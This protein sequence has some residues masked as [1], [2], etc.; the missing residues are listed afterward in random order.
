MSANLNYVGQRLSLRKPQAESLEILSKFIKSVSL[1]KNT[2]NEDALKAF[3]SS[4]KFEKLVDFEREFPSVTFALATGVGKT[5]L[6]GAF[7]SYLYKEKG[8]RNFLV[9]APNLTIYNKL[10]TDFGNFS[11][12]KYV[13]R[14]I[15][16]EP[17]VITGDNYLKTNTVRF[18]SNKSGQYS[19][20]DDEVTI[21]IFNISKINSEARGG[22]APK[23][24]RTSEY[25]GE[26]YFQYLQNLDD[27]VLIMDESHHYRAS[28]GMKV[29]NELR[30]ILGLE[31]TA[32]PKLS[33]GQPFKNIVYEY[34]LAH[35]V[36]DGYVKEPA[37]AT[38]KNLTKAQLKDLAPEELDKMKLLDAMQIH[39]MTK[40]NLEIYARNNKRSIV[41][42]FVLVVAE[43]TRHAAELKQVIQSDTFCNGRYADKVFDVHSSQTGSELEENVQ[44]LLEL[45]DPKNKFEIVIHCNMLKE[46]WD[47]T[48]L[49]TIVPL[50]SFAANILTEQTL[51]RGLRLP[52]GE[53][54][55]DPAVDTLTVIA[56]ESF[57]ALIDEAK[58]PGSILMKQYFIDPDNE[59]Y[60]K[61]Q[62]VVVSSSPADQAIQEEEKKA[63]EIKDPG[64]RQEALSK[65]DVKKEIFEQVFS[66]NNVVNVGDLSKE[67]VKE[68]IKEEILKKKND[69]LILTEVTEEQ[70]ELFFDQS[71]DKIVE[72]IVEKTIEIPRITIQLK[73]DTKFGFKDFNLD[74]KNMAKFPV[75]EHEIL[76]R[77]LQEQKK[78]YT[79]AV[80]NMGASGDQSWVNILVNE[81]LNYDEIDYDE[82][83]DLIYKLAGQALEH[84]KSYLKDDKEVENVIQY[85]KQ[86]IA[87][88]IYTQMMEKFFCK[89]GEFERADIK[90]FSKIE[91][92]NYSKFKQDE[93][94]N[95]RDHVAS[96]ADLYK[97]VFDYYEKS[98]HTFYKYDSMPEKDFASLLDEDKDVL[99]WM[100]P[101]IRQFNI[102]WD[103]QSRMYEPDFVVETKENIYL[104]EVKA[105]NELS[106]SEVIEKAKAAIEYCRLAS[107]YAK[108]NRK[109]PWTYLLVP[110]DEITSSRGFK[111]FLSFN[112]IQE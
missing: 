75:V 70:V 37:A 105:K 15:Q 95:S 36:K 16:I 45:E 67:K 18:T 60:K 43:D 58:K 68:I 80:T 72:S 73:N 41:K 9:L 66:S 81:L 49:Y 86:K 29:L 14:G 100:K 46:G 8:L 40:S 1:D 55:G 34:T 64:K 12:P 71:Y 26:S 24:R 52:Y 101:S 88:L 38:R 107:D 11:H 83:S 31:L 87:E 111:H 22:K 63:K 30:P 20:Y 82:H 19:M 32:T 85:Y 42:P 25:F 84:L 5:R 112:T 27:L 48:N 78:T 7:I 2:K 89:T 44:R 104:V 97:H 74:T 35:A 103:H 50:R 109:K 92:H 17:R 79:Y 90:P 93:I 110:H 76:V 59:I 4:G 99:K 108:E 69:G 54:T 6:M 21:N 65:V 10:I 3:K 98:C 62:E 51:G 91:S 56:H 57:E 23:I 47:V 94:K 53:K 39:E 61:D 28:A 102:Y 33:N 106:D 77:Y 96:R 13:F